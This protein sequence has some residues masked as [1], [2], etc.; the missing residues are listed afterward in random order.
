MLLCGQARTGRNVS[1]TLEIPPVDQGGGGR[2]EQ[3]S[4]ELRL[5]QGAVLAAGMGAKNSAYTPD[6]Q[7]ACHLAEEAHLYQPG[8]AAQL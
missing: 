1:R 3:V 8:L 5:E 7:R 2:H 6:S 4:E